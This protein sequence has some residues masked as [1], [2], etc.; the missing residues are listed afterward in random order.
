MNSLTLTVYR[1]AI[2]L[3]LLLAAS[4][5]KDAPLTEEPDPVFGEPVVK[6]KGQPVGD[7]VSAMIGPDGGVLLYG[8]VI[9]M[10]IPPGAVDELTT[11][12]IQPIGN[13][14]DE[15]SANPAFR[16]T[17]EGI[18]FNKPVELSFLY[19][20]DA[21]GNPATR[22][23]AFQRRDGAWCGSSTE[24]NVSQ[25]RLTVETT[26]FSDWVWFDLLSLRKDKESVGAGETVN[27][28]LLE[29]VLAELMPTSH[30]DSVPLAAMD[31]IGFSKDL[32]VSGWK[33]ISGPGSL[34]PKINTNMVPGDAVYTAPTTI[35]RATDVEIQVEVESKNGYIS[36]RGAPGGRRKLGKLI[37]LT[38]IRLVPENLVQLIVNGVEQDLSKT[39]NDAKLVNG[40]VYI[41]LGGDESPITLTLQCFGTGPGT[42][43][44]GTDSGEAVLYYTTYRGGQRRNAVSFYRTCEND[45]IFN[46]TATLTDVGQYIEGS[47][48]GLIFPM[49]VQNC[50]VPPSTTV[51]LNFKISNGSPSI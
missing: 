24:L 46:G 29:Q 20:P 21:E 23:V 39:G 10:E 37:L 22:M 6:P 50:E 41:R 1:F 40:S 36:D 15:T 47:F 48:S 33:I 3:P 34:S 12:S 27:L 28:K 32:T 18:R 7:A 19:D 51:V 25:R 16:L 11:F 8:D 49:D 26:H 42:Y 17:P 13:T 43:P 31:D 35:E 38:T 4:C 30:I 14:L 2:M 9:R 45:H 44:G 5:N